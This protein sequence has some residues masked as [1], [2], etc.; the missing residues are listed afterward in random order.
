ME[1]KSEFSDYI[2]YVDES[3]D[4]SLTS[5]DA[6]YPVFVLSFCVFRKDDYAERVTPAVR[7]HKFEV[8]GHDMVVL[9]EHEIR[10]KTG[11]FARLG[12]EAR[13]KFMDSLTSV[14][15]VAD[16]MLIAVVIDKRRLASK[17]ANPAHPYHLAMAFG[18]E[19][20][21]RLL[22][23]RGQ[24]DRTTHIVCEARGPKEDAELELEFRR[25]RDGANYL[26]KRL[27]F[28]LVIADKK[29]N[30]EGMQLADLTARPIGLSV[31]RPEQTNRAMAILE[32]KFY[33][34]G[35]GNKGGFGLKVFP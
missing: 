16:F 15:E 19:R 2:V 25:I 30:S 22:H 8:F 33:R 26:N 9:H 11:A 32:N 14:I 1:S 18:L 23:S 12:K 5:I 4:H 3:G 21:Y 7:K 10:K 20:L 35:T 31:L 6:G 34:D 24:D 17:Y 28:E 29:T 13:E 27:P